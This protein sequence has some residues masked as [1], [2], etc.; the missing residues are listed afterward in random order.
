MGPLHFLVT[1][2]QR[3]WWLTVGGCSMDTARCMQVHQVSIILGGPGYQ[4]GSSRCFG[5]SWLKVLVAN[6]VVG[7]RRQRRDPGCLLGFHLAGW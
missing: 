7:E 2:S 5:T 6:C 1:A 4:D 3:I